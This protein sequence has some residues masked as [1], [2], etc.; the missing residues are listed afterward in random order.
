V[1]GALLAALACAGCGVE[2]VPDAVLQTAPIADVRAV[3]PEPVL[4][5]AP[6]PP[7]EPPAEVAEPDAAAEDQVFALAN[8]ARAEAGLAPLE[9]M[10]EIDVVAR[11]WSTHLATGGL[12]LA[13]NPDF[14]AQIPPGWSSAAENV[15]WM[16]DNG[17]LS[18]DAV[19]ERIHQGWMDSPGHRENL[20]NPAY[21][22]IGVGVA[23][24][25]EH[26]WYLTQNFAT[27]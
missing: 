22:R 7:A 6:E 4:P 10:T 8:A 16:Q 25:A 3:P 19:A 26:G 11:A 21:T 9:R 15:G 14:S 13:H 23:H 12:D 27:Y 1:L 24:S 5:P 18:A 2:R 17:Q 20:L